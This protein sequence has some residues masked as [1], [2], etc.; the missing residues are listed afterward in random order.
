M[1]E[2]DAAGPAHAALI[3]KL[4]QGYRILLTRAVKGVY[5][6]CEDEQT[7]DRLRDCLGISG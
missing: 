3:E 4:I 5:V 6:W 7:K 2:K 1:A